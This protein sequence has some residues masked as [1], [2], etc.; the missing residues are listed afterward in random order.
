MTEAGGRD[1]AVRTTSR[2]LAI[3]TTPA[4]APGQRNSEA[5]GPV[6]ELLRLA[7]GPPSPADQPRVQFPLRGIRGT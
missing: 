4:A 1:G 2:C 7:L 3:R 6:Y 5:L